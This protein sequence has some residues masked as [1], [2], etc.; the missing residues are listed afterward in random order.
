MPKKTTSTKS[1]PFLRRLLLVS[2]VLFALA[3]TARA[4][5]PPAEV[6]RLNEVQGSVTFAP[7]GSADWAYAPLNR[8]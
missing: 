4:D 8:P 5:D 3:P 1:G 7:S 6:A 2:S